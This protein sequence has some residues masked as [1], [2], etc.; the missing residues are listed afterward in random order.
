MHEHTQYTQKRK[1]HT[2]LLQHEQ[3]EKLIREQVQAR[4]R[5]FQQQQTQAKR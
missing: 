5:A 2:W 1:A 3:R 4:R